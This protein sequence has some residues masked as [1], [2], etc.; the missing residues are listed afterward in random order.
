MMKEKDTPDGNSEA[1]ETESEQTE[2][3][4]PEEKQG[5]VQESDLAKVDIVTGEKKVTMSA[6][7]KEFEDF[8]NSFKSMMLAFANFIEAA[9]LEIGKDETSAKINT[10]ILEFEQLKEE[11]RADEAKMREELVPREEFEEFKAVTEDK[12]EKAIEDYVRRDEFEKFRSAIRE[13]I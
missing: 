12:E 3:I 2:F 7:V 11:L 5:E 9:G 1:Q 13:V 6:P 4:E 8:K 10:L